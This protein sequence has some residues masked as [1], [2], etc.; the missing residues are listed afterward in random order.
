MSDARSYFTHAVPGYWMYETSG[1]LRP[2]IEAYLAGG[3][4]TAEQVAIMRV[5]LRQWM[6]CPWR[7]PLIIMLR[8]MID[9]IG[10]REDIA[11]WLRAAEREGID[12]L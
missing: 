2:V 1:K 4:M 6:A 5:Y 11:A 9:D 12:P 3:P 7:G 8:R 10:T